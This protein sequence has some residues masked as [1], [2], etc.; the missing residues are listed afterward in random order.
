MR[1]LER[2]SRYRMSTSMQSSAAFDVLHARHPAACFLTIPVSDTPLII[3]RKLDLFSSLLIVVNAPSPQVKLVAFAQTYDRP[4]ATHEPLLLGALTLS[5]S[6]GPCETNPLLGGRAF[7]SHVCFCLPLHRPLKPSTTSL[8][9][10]I[11]HGLCLV[12]PLRLRVAHG[13]SG[14][15]M[16]RGRFMVGNRQHTTCS[17]RSLRMAYPACLRSERFALPHSGRRLTRLQIACLCGV[18]QLGRIQLLSS[19]P[20][21]RTGAL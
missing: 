1:K 7:C 9:C 10:R 18:R 12:A 3:A 21:S 5:T 17:T 20:V 15:V 14:H 16:K 4:R 13:T 6:R 8:T 19:L 11:L 2:A